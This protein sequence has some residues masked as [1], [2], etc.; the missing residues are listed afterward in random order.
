MTF[1]ARAAAAVGNCSGFCL[2]RLAAVALERSRGGE[3]A[4]PM[5]DHV[6]RHEHLH[7]HLA[8]VNH[9]RQAHELRHDRAGPGP[10]LDRLLRA[11][12]L[13]QPAPS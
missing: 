5:A 8:V 4:Q 13:L 9:E 12:L 1:S 6:F 11:D 3:L 2:L 10:R 7:V